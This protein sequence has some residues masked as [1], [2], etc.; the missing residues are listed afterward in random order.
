M[1]VI[2]GVSSSLS[3]FDWLY[4]KHQT[5]TQCHVSAHVI[6]LSQCSMACLV[7]VSHM[8]NMC[9]W[10]KGL[11]AQVTTECCLHKKHVCSHVAQHGT[12]SL[13]IPPS[14]STSS[15]LTCTPI[16]PSTRPSTGP[17]QI[18]SSDEMYHCDDPINVSFG[19]L[20]DLHYIGISFQPP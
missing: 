3:L 10:L 8:H 18:S 1:I 19:S 9:M 6:F 15:L 16:R 4:T 12:P 11:T 2:A 13:M 20:A 5:R 14:L 17:L 7:S